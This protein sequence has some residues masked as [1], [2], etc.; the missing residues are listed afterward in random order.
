MAQY[1]QLPSAQRRQLA[2]RL[3]VLKPH[4]LSAELTSQ[5][6]HLIASLSPSSL[7]REGTEETD[8]EGLLS[9]RLFHDLAPAPPLPR[10]VVYEQDDIDHL[11]RLLQE[12]EQQQV[13]PLTCPCHPLL[14]SYLC[15]LSPGFPCSPLVSVEWLP[16]DDYRQCYGLLLPL[17][18][19]SALSL[20]PSSPLILSLSIS[21]GLA[22]FHRSLPPQPA[23]RE[24]LRSLFLSLVL[25][26]HPLLFPASTYLSALLRLW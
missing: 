23:T 22:V 8:T 7:S 17:G 20:S 1:A 9:L 10:R 16:L 21:P 11:L 15:L 19:P 5:L 24:P 26:H 13:S 4:F 6:L 14:S 25:P 18:L 3:F 2:L 12:Q